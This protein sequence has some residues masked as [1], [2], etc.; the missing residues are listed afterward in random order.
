MDLALAQVEVD[1]VVG[2]DAREPL[3]DAAELEERRLRA[4]EGREGRARAPPLD[5]FVCAYSTSVGDLDLAVDDLCSIC[6]TLVEDL[7]RHVRR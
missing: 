5:P 7:L 4:S 2:D 1:V 6:A 3:G